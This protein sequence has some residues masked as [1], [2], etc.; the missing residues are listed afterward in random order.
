M[1]DLF[2]DGRT[3][4]T[5]PDDGVG[6]RFA[7]RTIPQD[8][9]FALVGNADGCNFTRLAASLRECLARSC[10][11]RLPN[12]LRVMFNLPGVGENLLK[13]LLGRRNRLSIVTEDDRPAAG[14]PL[15]EG[16]DE[17][18]HDWAAPGWS[19]RRTGALY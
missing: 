2:A 16:E 10:Q 15:I 7:R 19:R 8:D 3:D 1:F 6:D 13:L 17:F 18:A 5:L 11:L 4:S 14:G 12:C 9:R